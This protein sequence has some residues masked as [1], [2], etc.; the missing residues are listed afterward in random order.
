MILDKNFVILAEEIKKRMKLKK[1][2]K[3]TKD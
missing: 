2:I 3:D 1:E